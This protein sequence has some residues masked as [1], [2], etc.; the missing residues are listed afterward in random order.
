MVG[1]CVACDAQRAAVAAQ[2]QVQQ[3]AAKDASRSSKRN[4]GK[5]NWAVEDLE[6]EVAVAE[7]AAR[8]RRRRRRR[9]REEEEETEEEEQWQQSAGTLKS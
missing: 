2:A 4:I 7:Y 1:G 3:A 6:Q 5:R 8:R 9:R